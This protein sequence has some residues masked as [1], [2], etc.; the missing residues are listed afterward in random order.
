MSGLVDDIAGEVSGGLDGLNFMVSD[1]D[2]FLSL[3]E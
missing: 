2:D 3:L 1:V